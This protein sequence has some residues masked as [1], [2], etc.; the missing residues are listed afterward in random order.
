[1]K[2]FNTLVKIVE[3]LDDK[4]QIIINGKVRGLKGAIRLNSMNLSLY[5]KLVMKDNS[6]LLIVP[7][8]EIIYFSEKYLQKFD[9]HDDLIGQE[10]LIYNDEEY[11]CENKDDYQYVERLI[12]GNFRD[13]EGEVK[14][15]DY[16]LKDHPDKRILSLGW[17]MKNGERADLMAERIEIDN[18][19][20]L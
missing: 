19:Q 15:S 3:A 10:S 20:I 8:E 2:N 13:L 1:M 6:Y 9:I 12:F 18:I 14:F 17:F 5:Y 11:I 16:I 4:D 7:S